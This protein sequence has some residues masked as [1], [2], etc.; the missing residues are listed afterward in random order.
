VDKAKFADCPRA[1]KPGGIYRDAT[2]PV[3][4]PH[5]RWAALT[6]DKT[7]VAG[8]HPPATADALEFLRG[9]IEEGKLRSAIDRTYPLEQ[10]VEAHRYVDLGHKKGNVVITA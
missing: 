2:M 5:M 10:I 1:L 3:R 9:L 8:E 4:T 7:I 6:S